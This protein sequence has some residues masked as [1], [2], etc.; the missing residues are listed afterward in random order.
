MNVVPEKLQGGVKELQKAL[1]ARRS[2]TGALTKALDDMS[3][4]TLKDCGRVA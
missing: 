1:A 3:H 2:T 4:Q